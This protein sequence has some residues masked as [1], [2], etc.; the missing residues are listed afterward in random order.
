MG[1]AGTAKTL[2]GLSS[3]CVEDVTAFAEIVTVTSKDTGGSLAKH[4]L[5]GGPEICEEPVHAV[6]V[7]VE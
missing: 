4:P 3:L 2:M 1:I 7:R 6:K 5:T